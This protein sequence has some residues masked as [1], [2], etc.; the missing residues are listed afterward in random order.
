MRKLLMVIM[1]MFLVVTVVFSEDIDII[2]SYLD[3]I[4][5]RELTQEDVDLYYSTYKSYEEYE[6]LG[7]FLEARIDL[8][9]FNYKGGY[10]KL[11]KTL[12]IT[13][14]D[15]LLLEVNYY[16]AEMDSEFYNV[17]SSILRANEAKALAEKLNEKKRL[18]DIKYIIAFIYSD[19]YDSKEGLRFA[20]K[21][22]SLSEDIDYNLGVAKSYLFLVNQDYY[23]DNYEGVLEYIK[24]AKEAIGDKYVNYIVSDITLQFKFYEIDALYALGEVEDIE[25]SLLSILD[26]VKPEDTYNISYIYQYLGAYYFEVDKHKAIEYYEKSLNFYNETLMIPNGYDFGADIALELGLLYYEIENYEKASAFLYDSIINYYDA[27]DEDYS[28]LFEQLDEYKFENINER[29][30]LLKEVNTLKDKEIMLSRRLLIVSVVLIFLLLLGTFFLIFEIRSKQKVEKELYINSITDDLTKAFNRGKIIDIIENNLSDEN[31]LILLDVDDFKAINDTY[32]H[33]VGDVVLIKIADV[34]LHS[35]R[36]HD[37]L[38]RY[39]G[40]EFLVFLKGVQEEELL[41][42]AER[43]RL[44]IENIEWELDIKTTASIGVTKCFSSDFEEVFHKVDDLMYRAKGAGK[45]QVIKEN[46]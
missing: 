36:D 34:I 24:K 13:E 35:I 45:N 1:L 6:A 28:K 15:R 32:G 7:L 17:S 20:E 46:D 38:G 37:Y 5:T 22:L 2:E 19:T 44:S 11:E 30:D 43:I 4:E 42:I 8:Y 39:G 10:E 29:I 18:A 40:E 25:E 23:N 21:S 27:S 3:I 33:S 41:Y 9:K 12:E 26:D 14:N 31:G 16:L